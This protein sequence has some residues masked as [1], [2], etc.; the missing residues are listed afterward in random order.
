MVK[1]QQHP[2]VYKKLLAWLRTR[3]YKLSKVVRIPQDALPSEVPK[4]FHDIIE[5]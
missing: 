2:S 4:E 5:F 1:L 3:V